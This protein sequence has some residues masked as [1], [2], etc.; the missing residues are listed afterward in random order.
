M[1]EIN[2]TLDENARKS[3]EHWYHERRSNPSAEGNFARFGDFNHLVDDYLTRTRKIVERALENSEFNGQGSLEFRLERDDHALASYRVNE[4][5]T[6]TGK[7]GLNFHKLFHALF[8]DNPSH[9]EPDYIKTVSHEL[10][11]HFDRKFSLYML[12]CLDDKLIYNC[13]SE[14][15]EHVESVNSE[16]YLLRNLFELRTEGFADFDGNLSRGKADGPQRD[17]ADSFLRE[18][19]GVNDVQKYRADLFLNQLADHTE[20]VVKTFDFLGERP[21][22]SYQD[23]F[24][25]IGK[26]KYGAHLSSLDVP[27]PFSP[28]SQGKLLFNVIALAELAKKS[29][30]SDLRSLFEETE[31]P[32]DVCR[33]VSKRVSELDTL[34]DFYD[35]F[36]ESAERLGLDD[37]HIIVPKE[38]VERYALSV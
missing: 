24:D 14:N 7:F 38:Y 3:M 17:K 10:R 18:V 35:L 33:D 5:T 21:I 32:K 4:S 34:G 9:T 15:P 31:I 13:S 6:N 26:S 2:I 1:A 16:N 11:H 30:R 28:Y 23:Y 36:Y 37:S 20:T 8:N 12:G 19:L 22:C 27:E 29:G 25:A